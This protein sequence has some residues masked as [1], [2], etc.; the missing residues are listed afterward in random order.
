MDPAVTNVDPIPIYDTDPDLV[1]TMLDIQIQL[2]LK[3]KGFP[4]P[5]LS[6]RNK[7]LTPVTVNST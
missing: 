6:E 7:T 3:Y 1:L 4:D 5:T 2:D